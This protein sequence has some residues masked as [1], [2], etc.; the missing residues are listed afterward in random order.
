MHSRHLPRAKCKFC[1]KTWV[2]YRNEAH[3][4]I[5]TNREKITKAF[6]ML[7]IRMSI[8]KIAREINV[9]PTTVQRWK[10]NVQ[11]YSLILHL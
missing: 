5:R 2:T 7:T 6:E 4:R 11:N 8:R 1:G 10:K 3:Y 9:S